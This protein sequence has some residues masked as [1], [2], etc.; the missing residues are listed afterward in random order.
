MK[1]IAIPLLVAGSANAQLGD[2]SADKAVMAPTLIATTLL[3]DGCT[4]DAV[5]LAKTALA[6]QDGILGTARAA[7]TLVPAG[8]GA[9]SPQTIFDEALA[10]RVLASDAVQV[11]QTAADGLFVTDDAARAAVAAARLA[12]GTAEAIRTA[13]AEVD[14]LAGVAKT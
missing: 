7:I 4:D 14:R 5:M 10:A 8:D 2:M 13:A 1:N 9:K 6:T 12:L 3:A 11:A